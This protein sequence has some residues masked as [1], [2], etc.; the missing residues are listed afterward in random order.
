MKDLL[1]GAEALL[2]RAGAVTGTGV[3]ALRGLCRDPSPALPAALC[4]WKPLLRMAHWRGGQVPVFFILPWG[5]SLPR[6]ALG[7]FC[8]I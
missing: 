6:A 1:P 3:P 5:K 2:P 4:T 8:P 7:G